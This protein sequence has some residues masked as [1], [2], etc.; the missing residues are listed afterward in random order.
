MSLK[1]YCWVGSG[2]EVCLYLSIAGPAF[3]CRAPREKIEGDDGTGEGRV[4]HIKMLSGAGGGGAGGGSG[5]GRGGGVGGEKEEEEK[6]VSHIKMLSG[7]H[8]PLPPSRG[9][10]RGVESKTKLHKSFSE[11]FRIQDSPPRSSSQPKNGPIFSFAPIEFRVFH[12]TL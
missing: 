7:V 3:P 5:G 8:C 12:R 4:S 11:T 10:Q 2:V 9:G 6:M 1:H